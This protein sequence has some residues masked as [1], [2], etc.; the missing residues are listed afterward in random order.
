LRAENSAKLTNIL[1]ELR[2]LIKNQEDY[3]FL[4][5][6]WV[7]LL[8]EEEEDRFRW[9]SANYASGGFSESSLKS[10]KSLVLIEINEKY[11]KIVGEDTGRINNQGSIN[12]LGVRST[13]GD[14]ILSKL[15]VSH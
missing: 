12:S 9:L 8:S 13:T 6:S 10:N 11:E 7:G 14:G 3:I 1:S 5:D 4:E 15:L 2:L